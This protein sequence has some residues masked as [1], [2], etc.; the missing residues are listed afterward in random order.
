MKLSES[1][2]LFASRIQAELDEEL[3]ALPL[4]VFDEVESTN[5]LAYQFIAQ[6][7]QPILAV[8][9]ETQTS[10]RGRRGRAWTSPKGTGLLLSVALSFTP[11]DA[12]HYEEWPLLAAYVAHK[13]ISDLTG[14]RAQIKWPNDIL[15]GERKTCGIL[16][17]LSSTRDKRNLIVGFGINVNLK[18][19]DLPPELR[20]KATSLLEVTGREYD[21]NQLTA[22][23]LTQMHLL[24]KQVLNGMRFSDLHE[25]WVAQCH[26]IGKH[27]RV[28]QG[29]DIIEGTAHSIDPLGVLLVVDDQGKLHRIVSGEILESH[30]FTHLPKEGVL[31]L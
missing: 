31:P 21:R 27:I 3:R 9:A 11:S 10:G 28:A 8:L 25:T 5:D 7:S 22:A 2:R 14:V 6:S 4:Y 15:L 1:P 18:S 29:R 16:T 23:I 30:P 24:R 13:V 19:T 17:E 26:T 12:V 20:T